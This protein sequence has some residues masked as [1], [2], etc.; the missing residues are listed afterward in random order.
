MNQYARV[1]LRG[2]LVHE[3]V[4]GKWKLVIDG[5]LAAL[6]L[7]LQPAQPASGISDLVLSMMR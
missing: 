4:K 7:E 3:L 5:L 6:M 2:S 1:A